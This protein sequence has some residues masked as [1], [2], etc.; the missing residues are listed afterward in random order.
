MA[1]A[2]VVTV[3]QTIMDGT[4]VRWYESE[5]TFEYGREMVSASRNGVMVPRYLNAVPDDVLAAAR[6]AWRALSKGRDVGHLATH[7]ITFASRELRPAGGD[8]GG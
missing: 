1:D 3:T 6:D 2:P 8:A 5:A 4:V 7:R